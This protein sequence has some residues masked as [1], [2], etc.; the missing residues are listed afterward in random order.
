V[1]RRAALLCPPVLRKLA[2]RYRMTDISMSRLGTPMLPGLEWSR[3]MGEAVSWAFTR[4]Y[5][6]RKAAEAHRQAALANHAMTNLDW[7]GLS[8]WKK[9]LRVLLGK[10]PRAGTMYSIQRALDFRPATTNSPYSASA[11]VP[12]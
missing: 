6:G 12:V 7:E 9:A 3:S 8:R 2:T 11:R 10:V 1:L 5:P 4:A